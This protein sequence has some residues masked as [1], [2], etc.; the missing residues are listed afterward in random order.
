MALSVFVTTIWH[1][2]S[3][4][5]GV[6]G[7][8]VVFKTTRT[9]HLGSTIYPGQVVK[10]LPSGFKQAANLRGNKLKS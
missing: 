10:S 6:E 5:R 8:G 1:N 7:K 2:F 9:Y 3:S 4:C